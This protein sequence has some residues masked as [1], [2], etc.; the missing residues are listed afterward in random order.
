MRVQF[1]GRRV[2][3]IRRPSVI[4]LG[5]GGWGGPLLQL[6]VPNEEVDFGF[7]QNLLCELLGMKLPETCVEATFEKIR[8]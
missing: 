1:V 3:F 7:C 4:A 6:L 8:N 2:L 5:G